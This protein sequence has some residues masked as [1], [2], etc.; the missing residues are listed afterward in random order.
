MFMFYVLEI[1]KVDDIVEREI[2]IWSHDQIKCVWPHTYIKKYFFNNKEEIDKKKMI[3]Y[4]K[5]H[6][7]MCVFKHY[8]FGIVIM[9]E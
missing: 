3:E 8:W 1:N 2:L 7:L 9:E 4:F 5:D 6:L